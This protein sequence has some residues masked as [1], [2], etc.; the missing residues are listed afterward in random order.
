MPGCGARTGLEAPSPEPAVTPRSSAFCASATYRSGTTETSLLLVLDKSGS[1]RDDGKWDQVTA[2]IGA[3][4]EAP[5]NT[6]LAMGLSYFPLGWSCDVARY[7]APA[8]PVGLLPANAA[9]MRASLAAQTIDGDTPTLPALR[10]AIEYAR[11]LA[12]ADPSRSVV[13]ALATD[14]AP[15]V[16]NSTAQR[17]AEVAREGAT[18]DPQVLTF[19]V[20]VL[21]GYVDALGRIA[22]SGGT[23]SPIFLHDAQS[24]AAEFTAALRYLR[25]TQAQ[26]RFALPGMGSATPAA[27][28][29]AVE[30]ALVPG[31]PPVDLPIVASAADCGA[32]AGFFPDDLAHPARVMLCPT[33]C[34][35]VH[36]SA[37]SRVRV[38]AGC[39]AGAGDAG[40]PGNP[41][42]G[43]CAGAV[44]FQCLTACGAAG[45]TLPVCDGSDWVCPPGTISTDACSSCPP[46]PHGCCK[47]D[48][49]FADAACLGGAWVCAPG[50]SLFGTADCS[51]PDV[52]TRIL[53]CALGLVCEHPDY[54][55]G[56]SSVLGRCV[57]PP[58]ACG[59]GVP[60]CGCDGAPY[61]SRCESAVAGQDVSSSACVPPLGTFACGP[62]FCREADEVC[63]RTTDLAKTIA[64]N[65]YACI[66]A[67]PA[68]PTGCGCGACLPCPAGR[69]CKEACTTGGPG[70][71][72]LTCTEL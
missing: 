34:A 61:A 42:G 65:E 29:L 14:G 5:D 26:C 44:S 62:L 68:C 36:A 8:V 12:L 58:A 20:G 47:A 67:T 4:V 37:P 9:A 10:G 69:V 25:E 13:V 59:P 56:A 19:V 32:K 22:E 43:T 63:K 46:V 16:C 27:T 57:T 1:M 48:G 24:S 72:Y 35:A 40:V 70:E 21:T 54:A 66:V 6:G 33:S 17:V 55:C 45:M 31:A 71:R 49:T 23:G 60:A 38:I 64:P 39:G 28:D 11:A 53:P 50:T 52:C 15:N 2:A 30:Y 7:A 51:P 41:D 3:F 18:T